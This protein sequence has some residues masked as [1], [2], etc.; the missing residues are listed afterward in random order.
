MSDLSIATPDSG[1]DILPLARR[2]LQIPKEKWMY[3]ITAS[4]I[5]AL[6]FGNMQHVSSSFASIEDLG[7]E[8]VGYILGFGVSITMFAIGVGITV[9]RENGQSSRSLYG[10]LGFFGFL[11]VYA[12][13]NYSLTVLAETT[14]WV[15]AFLKHP[16]YI[17]GKIVFLSVTI[18][19]LVFALV[20]LLAA[21]NV[22]WKNIAKSRKASE[23]QKQRKERKRAPDSL[24]TSE[25]VAAPPLP[26]PALSRKELTRALEEKVGKQRRGRV[27]KVYAPK[28]LGYTP[29]API[30][31][32][33]TTPAIKQPMRRDLDA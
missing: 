31:A 8:W 7:Y 15:A 19:F 6:I 28:S 26:P 4:S 27:G 20:R 30:P 2:L 1:F 32:P 16:Y 5:F 25:P 18:P 21:F 29:G 33:V 12:N 9:E 3:Y 24:A 23:A 14:D 11:E 10:Y 17:L 13:V 22:T